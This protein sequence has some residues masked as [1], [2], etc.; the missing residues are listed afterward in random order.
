MLSG[1]SKNS[2]DLT[3]D[4]NKIAKGSKI[5]GNLFSEGSIRIE[6]EIEGKLE[7]KG[8]VVVGKTG[9]VNGEIYCGC[10]DIEGKTFGSIV[11]DT[12]LSLKKTAD[13]NGEVTTDK[14]VVEAG[15]QFNA[16]CK[17]KASVKSINDIKEKPKPEQQTKQA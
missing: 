13:I 3:K 8:K 1:K 14:L 10:A 6:G 9:V 16:T 7:V 15:A 12:V 11:V 2:Y 5:T 4:Q 17:M